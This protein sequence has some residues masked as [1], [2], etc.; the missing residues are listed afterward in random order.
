MPWFSRSTP[1]NFPPLPWLDPRAIE[2]L[3]GLL[4]KDMT[5]LEHGAGG[6]TLWLAERV[7]KVT[8]VESDVDFYAALLKRVPANVEL[9]YKPNKMLLQPADLLLIDGEPLEDRREWILAAPELAKKYVVLDNANR[10]DYAKERE[11]LRKKFDHIKTVRCEIGLYLV[12]E[13]YARR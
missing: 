6:S 1:D 4:S 9:L 5:V 11:E 7:A 10:P 12:T 3:N 2:Y 8:S 13:F